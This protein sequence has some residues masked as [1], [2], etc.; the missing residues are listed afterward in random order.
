[1]ASAPKATARTGLAGAF[2]AGSL[3]VILTI[4]AVIIGL[5][6]LLPL[7][8]SSGATSIGGRVA[9]LE[10][11]RDGWQARLE[12]LQVDV[13]TL[14]SLDRIDRE[15]RTRLKMQ[16]P[17]DPHY[18]AVDAAPPQQEQL[19]GRFLPPAPEK[20]NAGSSLWDDLF[21]WISLP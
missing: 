13:A 12:E 4:A 20:T 5:A 15:A 19:P 8:Q 3:P 9:E 7:L 17:T 2:S 18:I 16:P 10:Q 11:E 14:G 6:A 1:M 21:G